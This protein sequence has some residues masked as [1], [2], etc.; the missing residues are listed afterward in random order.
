MLLSNARTVAKTTGA[1]VNGDSVVGAK[2]SFAAY[3]S[4]IT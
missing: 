1:S 3:R 2:P 4:A